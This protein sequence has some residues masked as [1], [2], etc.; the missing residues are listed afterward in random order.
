MKMDKET[1]KRKN[2]PN[3]DGGDNSMNDNSRN[4]SRVYFMAG[5]QVCYSRA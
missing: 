1:M 5:S 2:M 3:G 4:T